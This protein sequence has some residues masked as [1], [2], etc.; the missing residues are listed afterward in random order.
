MGAEDIDYAQL[1]VSRASRC[2][3]TALY[4]RLL[5]MASSMCPRCETDIFGRA[6]KVYLCVHLL[7][8]GLVMLAP[9]V[10]SV[11]ICTP[12]RRLRRDISQVVEETLSCVSA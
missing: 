4:E 1:C 7:V 8:S 3:Y 11:L 5:I 10:E 12:S 2:W 9:C 6:H